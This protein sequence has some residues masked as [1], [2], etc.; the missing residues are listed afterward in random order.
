MVSQPP[1]TS[2]PDLGLL[3]FLPPALTPEAIM[4]AASPSPAP[5]TAAPVSS[6]VGYGQPTL[7]L[8]VPTAAPGATPG[9]PS[10][11]APRASD[12]YSFTQ[13]FWRVNGR[14]PTEF[15]KEM[16]DETP[17]LT[18][19]LGRPPYR[20]ELLSAITARF[21]TTEAPPEPFVVEQ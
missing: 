13:E 2:G 7:P 17:R 14:F 21:E 10:A 18:A 16:V 3:S 6:S 8:P 9:L 15:D 11:T 19:Q 5:A 12:D 1:A 20:D 4:P